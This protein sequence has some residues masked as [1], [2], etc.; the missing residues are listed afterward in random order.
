M[1]EQ[2]HEKKVF[3]QNHEFFLETSWN[4][5]NKT[6]QTN[7]HDKNVFKHKNKERNIFLKKTNWEK[8]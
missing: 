1:F 5:L 8:L 7:I 3:E 2:N 6:F 4:F